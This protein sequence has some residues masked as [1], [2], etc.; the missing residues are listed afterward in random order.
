MLSSFTTRFRKF[1]WF[2]IFTFTLYSIPHFEILLPYKIHLFFSEAE[3][4][5]TPASETKALPAPE[6]ASTTPSGK[7]APPPEESS[8]SYSASAMSQGTGVGSGLGIP[9]SMPE[10]F[11]F[12]GVATYKIPIEVPPGRGGMAPEIPLT[13]NSYQGNTWVGVGWNLDM[14]AIQRSTKRGVSYSAN[15][16]VALI[17]GSSSELSPRN[18]WGTNYYASKI[19]GAY[20]KYYFNSSTGGWEVTAKDGT[21]YYYGSTLPSRQDNTYGIFKWCLDKVQDTK[22]NYLTITYWKDQGEIYLDRIDYAGNASLPTTNYV[23]FYLESRT[24][25]PVMYP[26]NSLVKTAYRLKTIEVFGNG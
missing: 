2:L 11:I 5:E 26:G 4:A 18:D 17:N 24:D 21:K 16:Y 20:T 23:K 25:I 9:I 3:A 8:I 7:E 14:G 10:N 13:Y 22:G 12:T 15:D 6:E 1:I 19:E